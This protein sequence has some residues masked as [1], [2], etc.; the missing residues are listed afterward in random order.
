[1]GNASNDSNKGRLWLGVFA[2]IGVLIAPLS[3]AREISA[4]RAE[5]EGFSSERLE[6]I[7]ELNARLVAAGKV[8][9]L[10]TVVARNGRIVYTNT[11]GNKGLEDARPLAAD[12]LFRI[13]SMSKPITAVAAM[14]LFEQGKFQLSDPVSKFVPEFAE[15]SVWTP[16][17]PVPAEKQMT[18][19]QLLT[20]TTGLSYGFDPRDPVD[21]AYR[22]ANIWAEKDLD[23]F[24][25]AIA[26]LPLKFEPGERWHYSVAVDITGLVVQRLS[27]QRFDEY[28]QEH[29]FGPLD[30]VDT[31]FEVPA[32]KAERFLP[33]HAIDPRSGKMVQ[34]SR[35]SAIALTGGCEAMCDY[36]EVTLFSGGGGLISSLRDY[37]RFAEA[38]RA[39]GTLD[40]NRILGSRTVDFIRQNHL[41]STTGAG[42]TGEQPTLGDGR[43]GVGFGLGFSVLTD[44]VAAGIFGSKGEY[45]WGGAAGTVF[46]IDPVED[47]VVVGLMQLM[48]GI[49]TYRSDLRVATYQSLID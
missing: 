24:A 42:A 12:D 2:L 5:R 48:G 26:K 47:I 34:M 6:R 43:P 31:F 4:V 39:G 40:G 38:M 10:A 9:G 15:L 30:M 8:V 21:Q 1:M 46:W 18:M 36:D 14:Q 29:I 33:N 35:E 44:P 16:D 45:A 3:L 13:Y 49:D 27:G 25:T 20:H 11:V 32:D 17:G 23:A 41:G 7:G 22:E 19:H 28:L 37:L